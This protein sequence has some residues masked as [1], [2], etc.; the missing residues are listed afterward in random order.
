MMD[1]VGY[2]RCILCGDRGLLGDICH[3]C[4]ID[5]C[6]YMQDHAPEPWEYPEGVA[7]RMLW[8]TMNDEDGGGTTEL[9]AE[10]VNSGE[11]MSIDDEEGVD[12]EQI[13]DEEGVDTR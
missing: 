13:D 9:V 12:T 4:G 6:R 10:E 5:E 2:G 8:E 1:E 7:Q 11:D 3:Q